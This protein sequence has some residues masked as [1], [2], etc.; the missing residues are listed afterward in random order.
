VVVSSA[1]DTS[2]GLSM[3]AALAAALPAL[4]Y[5]C[6]LGTGALLAAD[7]TGEPLLPVDGVIPVRRVEA[8]PALLE[9]YSAAPDRDA[10]WRARL[11]RCAEILDVSSR[12]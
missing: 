11:T 9:R 2:V 12:S 4:E 1:L 7:V 5:D 6:G 8:D 3:G 10:W